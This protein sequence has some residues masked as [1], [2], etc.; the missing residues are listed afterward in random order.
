MKDAKIP[1]DCV[2]HLFFNRVAGGEALG[3]L[4]IPQGLHGAVQHLTGRRAFIVPQLA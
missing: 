2:H 1:G 4:I 3:F